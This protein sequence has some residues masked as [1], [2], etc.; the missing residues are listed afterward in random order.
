MTWRTLAH[1]ADSAAEIEAADL[2]GLFAD[3]ARA[4][5]S[6]VLEEPG[7]LPREALPVR[8]EAPDLPSLLVEWLEELLY[9]LDTRAFLAVEFE[10]QRLE[11]TALEAVIRGEPLD[12]QRHGAGREVKAVTW[13]GL[14]VE[15]QGQAWVARV[16]FDL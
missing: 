8:L 2:P 14:R 6:L 13:H 15:R 3:A 12:P 16:L 9:L 4:L 11:P 7:V 1:T 10:F 5:A